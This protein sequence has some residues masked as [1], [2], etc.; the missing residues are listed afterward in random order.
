MVFDQ[1]LYNCLINN[2]VDELMAQ[3]IAHLF[4]RD[5]IILFK[6]RLQIAENNDAQ[7]LQGSLLP[8]PEPDNFE[9]IQSTNWQT[10]RFKPPPFNQDEV[11]SQNRIG[12][13][14]EF[15]PIEVQFTEFENA[16]FVSFVILLSKAIKHFNLN[17]LIPISKVDV[18]MQRAQQI[19]ACLNDHFFFRT[20]CTTQDD[21]MVQ[22]MSIDQIVN[23]SEQFKGLVSY[24]N[25]YIELIGF[26][27]EVK[28]KLEK[29]LSLIEK[30]ANGSLSTPASY[31]RQFVRQHP[32]YK[33]DSVVSE[34]IN[35]DLM[36]HIYQ[37]Q[38]GDL[39]CAQLYADL[40]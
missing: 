7:R 25:D 20:N 32:D 3:H 8:E 39:K 38:N 30:R 11:E 4:I 1:N 35:Y 9:N 40:I 24:V 2:G 33:F 14:V 28:Q 10:M 13:R 19:N 12:W 17:F 34:R 16:A 5:P 26:E 21:C 15:R 22:E 18:N 29:Y 36:W 23:G 27:H 37:I 6:E 31:M